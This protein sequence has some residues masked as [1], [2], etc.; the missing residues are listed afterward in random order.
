MLK[1]HKAHNDYRVKVNFPEL[2]FKVVHV[3]LLAHLPPQPYFHIHI[4]SF[5]RQ[6]G[7]LII[8]PEYVQFI[9]SPPAFILTIHS[10]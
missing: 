2:A 5:S 4:L 8:P 6:N 10:T 7:F 9:L 3:L 1:A